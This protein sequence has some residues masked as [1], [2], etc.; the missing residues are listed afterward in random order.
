[1]LGA[2]WMSASQKDRRRPIKAGFHHQ[3]H[4]LFPEDRD[5]RSSMRDRRFRV[6]DHPRCRR[7]SRAVSRRCP[8]NPQGCKVLSQTGPSLADRGE[9]LRGYGSFFPLGKKLSKER[10]TD[11]IVRIASSRFA[12]YGLEALEKISETA[13]GHPFSPWTSML[14]LFART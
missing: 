13:F 12:S 4:R 10:I 5:L 2:L 6:E 14:C 7:P 1:M 3:C 8:A 11:E 9:N